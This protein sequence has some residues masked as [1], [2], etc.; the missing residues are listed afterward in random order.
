MTRA[1]IEQSI[2]RFDQIAGITP[3]RLTEGRA[4]GCRGFRVATGGGFAFTPIADRALDVSHADFKGI[5][6]CW[7]SASGEAAPAFCEPAGDEWLRTFF[8]GL[9]TTCGLTNF[10]PAG[11]D[12][13]GSFGLH[14]RVNCLPAEDVRHAQAWSGAEYV[15]EISGTI[16]QT[17]VLGEHLTLRRRLR[18][19]LGSKRLSVHDVVT[20]EGVDPTPHMILYHCN[21]GFPLLSDETRLYV[22][23]RKTT[24]RDEEAARGL[25]VWGC[26]GPPRA[27]FKEQVFIHEPVAC[28]SSR[29]VALLV[30]RRLNAGAGLA[31]AI[32]FDPR[33][34][35][36][37]FSWRK[38]DAGTYVMGMEP[39]NCATIEGRV[40]A[41]ERGT[42][43]MLEGGE[44]RTYD[45]EFEVLD[46][47]NG[48]AAAVSRIQSASA[49]R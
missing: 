42:L 49:S 29:T 6:L 23:S 12:R 48:I 44:S 21:G 39:A 14:G 38:L 11:C 46:E 15:M 1:Q 28:E 45:L 27:G 22:S 16:R 43:P 3:F 41:G 47:P 24:P 32:R 36:A 19:G 20:N 10:G 30:N 7:R 33:Q 5:P 9:F 17:K 13:W 35:P 26:G 31:L 8:G 2:G 40:A 37:F 34:L 4:Q 18:T 25:A